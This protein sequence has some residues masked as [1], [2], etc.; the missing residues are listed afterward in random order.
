MDFFSIGLKLCAYIIFVKGF[1]SIWNFSFFVNSV[2]SL[3]EYVNGNGGSNNTIVFLKQRRNMMNRKK[4]THSAQVWGDY[5]P[6][7][8]TY[9]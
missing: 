1:R 8:R 9:A 7:P 4:T 5:E 6:E 2:D 3:R